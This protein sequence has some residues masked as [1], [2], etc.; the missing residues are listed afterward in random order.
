M[1]TEMEL[2]APGFMEL[3]LSRLSIIEI[4]DLAAFPGERESQPEPSDSP[5]QPPAPGD[6]AVL[7][8]KAR[9]NADA[10]FPAKRKGFLRP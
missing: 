2:S 1:E 8:P 3:Q 10:I 9:V 7:K 4:D 6:M 5:S